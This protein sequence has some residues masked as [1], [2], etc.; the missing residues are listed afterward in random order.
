[1]TEE[2]IR[3]IAVSF[4]HGILVEAAR[5]VGVTNPFGLEDDIS[6]DLV[7]TELKIESEVDEFMENA[8]AISVSTKEK[9]RVMSYVFYSTIKFIVQR[10]SN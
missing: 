6:K 7:C 10:E 2:Q 1:M 4:L 3:K 9:A 8:A 5:L